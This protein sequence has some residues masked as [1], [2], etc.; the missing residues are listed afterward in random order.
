MSFFRSSLPES[1]PQ[2]RNRLK[3][4]LGMSW[5][6]QVEGDT[7]WNELD[8][9][10]SADWVQDDFELFA[11]AIDGLMDGLHDS[12]DENIDVDVGTWSK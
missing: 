11:D 5:E 4:H 10:Q 1:S 2:E 6:V 7:S 9:S 8:I 12:D 3:E